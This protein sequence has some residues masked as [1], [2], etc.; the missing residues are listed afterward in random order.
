MPDI[1]D[2][3]RIGQAGHLLDAAQALFEFD[4][5][6]IE[7]KDVV[8]GTVQHPVSDGS[9]G[10]PADTANDLAVHCAIDATSQKQSST[11]GAQNSP[12]GLST[13]SA[14]RGATAISRG[15]VA[16]VDFRVLQFVTVTIVD[17]AEC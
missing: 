15:L 10:S 3:H 13:M 14:I 6:T 8:D 2:K 7:I 5:L 1:D 12:P 4:A 16:I 11:G 17:A 9:A